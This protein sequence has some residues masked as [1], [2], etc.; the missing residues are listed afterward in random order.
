MIIKVNNYIIQINQIIY[1]G[2]NL[3]DLI[4]SSKTI[5]IK[6]LKFNKINKIL[7]VN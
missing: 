7:V 6:T 3:K 2:Y 4:K 1:K 5:L